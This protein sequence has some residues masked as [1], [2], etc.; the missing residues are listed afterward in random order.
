M[1][2]CTRDGCGVGTLSTS[3]GK[4]TVT[5]FP[6]RVLLGD[7]VDKV[8]PSS[9]VDRQERDGQLEPEPEPEP[10]PEREP[11]RDLAASRPAS[12]H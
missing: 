5:G 3:G 1:N 9:S 4:Y 10:E 12:P 6:K 7:K 2:S 11:E 8:E